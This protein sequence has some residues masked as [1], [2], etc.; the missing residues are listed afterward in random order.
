VR[1]E[2]TGQSS[3]GSSYN[4]ETTSRTYPPRRLWIWLERTWKLSGSFNRFYQVVAQGQRRDVKRE[5]DMDTRHGSKLARIEARRARQLE[6]E[7]ERA[8]VKCPATCQCLPIGTD[9]L[10][11]SAVDLA[12]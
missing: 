8:P 9:S 10:L 1:G 2:H 4:I 3:E 7:Q 11:P 5:D 12:S 6:L